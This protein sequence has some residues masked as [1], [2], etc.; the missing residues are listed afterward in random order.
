MDD[1]HV[2]LGALRVST[3][4]TKTR[5]RVVGGGGRAGAVSLWPTFSWSKILTTFQILITFQILTTFKNGATD[6]TGNERRVEGF[7]AILSYQG[8]EIDF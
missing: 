8:G 2:P 1:V 3:P 4:E 7:A 6:P 5:V